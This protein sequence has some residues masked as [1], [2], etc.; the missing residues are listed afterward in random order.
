MLSLSSFCLLLPGAARVGQAGRERALG[1]CGGAFGR[2]VTWGSPICSLLAGWRLCCSRGVGAQG[3][4]VVTVLVNAVGASNW[5]FS[6][7]VMSLSSRPRTPAHQEVGSPPPSHPEVGGVPKHNR[8]GLA[9]AQNAQDSPRAPVPT[10]E[11]STPPTRSYPSLQPPSPLTLSAPGILLILPTERLQ[12]ITAFNPHP[13]DSGR[14]RSSTS[15]LIHLSNIL[16]GSKLL[17]TCEREQSKTPVGDCVHV[18]VCVCILDSHAFKSV[19]PSVS[20][21]L[22]GGLCP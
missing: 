2:P 18:H 4:G 11:S 6:S 7:R 8:A 15:S 3:R 22:S 5:V 12:S 21:C 10:Q 1:G 20:M 14:S 19:C 9:P 17:S 13:L 16:G